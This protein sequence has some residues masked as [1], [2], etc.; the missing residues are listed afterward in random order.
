MA[1]PTFSFGEEAL[2]IDG[3]SIVVAVVALGASVIILTAGVSVA[4]AMVHRVFQ[5][6]TLAVDGKFNT[7]L[8]AFFF[9]TV[10]QSASGLYFRYRADGEVEFS[11]NGTSGW[12]EYGNSRR[13]KLIAE[14]GW[15]VQRARGLDYRKVHDV[16]DRLATSGETVHLNSVGTSASLE[17]RRTFVDSAPPRRRAYRRRGYRG[18]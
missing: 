2:P 12:Y 9:Q 13:S 17:G 14:H 5:R 6:V 4:F 8:H 18:F 16:Y 7:D 11:E 3:P 15:S 10:Y 1:T